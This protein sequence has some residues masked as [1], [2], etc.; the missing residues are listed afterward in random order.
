MFCVPYRN[1]NGQ[2]V[3]MQLHI[4]LSGDKVLLFSHLVSDELLVAEQLIENAAIEIDD[5]EANGDLEKLEHPETFKQLKSLLDCYISDSECQDL[6]S[7]LREKHWL[8]LRVRFEYAWKRIIE[9]NGKEI[10]KQKR[11]PP[12]M[13]DIA[14]TLIDAIIVLS[15]YFEE[16]EYGWYWSEKTG[17]IPELKILAALMKC[18]RFAAQSGEKEL[19]TGRAWVLY[20]QVLEMRCHVLLGNE[21]YITFMEQV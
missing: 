12:K 2:S 1:P 18:C 5:E 15:I 14:A 19:W 13:Y 17:I 4:I 6:Q 9:Q 16:Y 3:L 10:P 20:K 7:K 21:E 8:S 11:L